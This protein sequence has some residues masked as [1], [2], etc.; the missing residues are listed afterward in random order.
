MKPHSFR[1]ESSI[2]HGSV[3]RLLAIWLLAI[4]VE[5]PG[6]QPGPATPVSPLSSAM[7]DCKTNLN[8]LFEAIQEFH[9]VHRT[10]PDHL[11]DLHPE[12]ISDLNRFT[13]PEDLRNGRINSGRRGVRTEV[14][15]DVVPTGYSYEF[16]PKKYQLWTGIFSTDR[17]YK[18]RQMHVIGSNVPIVRCLVHRPIL[19]LSIGGTIFES[20]GEWEYSF[21]NQVPLARLLPPDIFKEL[22][23]KP[24]LPNPAIPKRDPKAEPRLLDLSNFYVTALQSP[25]LWRNPRG[26]DLSALPQGTVQLP[27]LPVSFDVRGLVQ[28]GGKNL[29]APFPERVDGIPVRQKCQRLHFLQGAIYPDP[30]G[31]ETGRYD[32]RFVDGT[33]VAIPIIYGRDVLAWDQ[34]PTSTAAE[35]RL[36]WKGPGASSN[37]IHHLYHQEWSNPR[38]NMEIASL[39]FV[40]TMTEAGPFLIAITLDP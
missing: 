11:S 24:G 29:F 8:R 18:L 21:A 37:R 22:A 17:E 31:T 27:S 16:C 4:A 10:W 35:L 9:K 34:A 5:S 14:F 6:E 30:P 28:L 40:S 7:E 23:P 33:R 38:P 25:W 13:C 19:N 12:F 36:A 3:A 2:T 20:P 1:S 32:V 15:E 26:H 39:D